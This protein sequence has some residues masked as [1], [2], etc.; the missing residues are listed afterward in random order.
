MGQYFTGIYLYAI[1]F[2]FYG[3]FLLGI[4]QYFC[5]IPK[6]EKEEQAH[7]MS[8]GASIFFG[9]FLGLFGV[10]YEISNILL[11]I[12]QIKNQVAILLSLLYIGRDGLE[13]ILMVFLDYAF[14]R[15]DQFY[16]T[17]QNKVSDIVD[18]AKA[19]EMDNLKSVV[20]ADNGV[21]LAGYA[22]SKI[23]EKLDKEEEK[24][25]EEK[26]EKNVGETRP[27]YEF[28]ET[29]LKDEFNKFLE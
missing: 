25:A 12:A 21:V 16:E 27:N 28:G 17:I 10:A 1:F 15:L 18:T 22:D 23:E 2:C 24:Q 4:S 3:V 7:A 29:Q 26:E 20:N 9:V 11:I 19:L 5:L 6:N 8:K 13:I 14:S